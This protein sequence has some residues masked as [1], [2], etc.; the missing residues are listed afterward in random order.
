[1][2]RLLY[3]KFAFHVKFICHFLGGQ[4]RAGHQATVEE[5]EM[6]RLAARDDK[7]KG[8]RAELCVCDHAPRSPS[9]SR[10]TM[11]SSDLKT[12]YALTNYYVQQHYSAE[13]SGYWRSS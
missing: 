7:F 6:P 1:M 8:I 10:G 13:H 3:D 2:T 12:Y 9:V 4:A 5:K 11:L